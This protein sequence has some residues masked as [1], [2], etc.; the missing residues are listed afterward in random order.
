MASSKPSNKDVIEVEG[1]VLDEAIEA[2]LVS[3]FVDGSL[4]LPDMFVL[5]FRDPDRTV[6]ERANI[7]IGK[8]VTISVV[9][10]ADPGGAKLIS[11]A[12]VTALEAEFDPAGTLT[13]VFFVT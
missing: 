9:S 2:L 8:K 12:E 13:T 1:T 11:N 4:N 7:E 10:D 3:A 6:L 5:T